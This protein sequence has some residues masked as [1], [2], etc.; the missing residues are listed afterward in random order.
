MNNLSSL[1]ATSPPTNSD[2]SATAQATAW[3]SKASSI[4]SMALASA[5]SVDVE[6]DS[7][8]AVITVALYNL[9]MLALL[10][11]KKEE[12][13]KLLAD[14]VDKAK[15]WKLIQAEIRAKEVLENL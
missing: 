15:Q 4:A 13:G 8:K 5:S 1:L 7:C 2:V 3:A 12:A 10:E 6:A 11:G 14:V 9:G